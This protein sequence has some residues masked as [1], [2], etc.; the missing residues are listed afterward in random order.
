MT[1]VRTK[2]ATT[3]V[4]AGAA[5]LF[6]SLG[7]APARPTSTL[8]ESVSA[9]SARAGW[10]PD[11]L[12]GKSGKLWMRLLT[13][14]RSDG[15]G[16]LR[17]L[18]GDSVADRPGVYTT[19]DSGTGRPFTFVTLVPFASKRKGTIGSYRLGAWPAEKRGKRSDA[20]ANPDGFIEVT[21]DN[22]ETRVSEHFRLRD[23]LTRDQ[24]SVWPK[25]LLLSEALLD[26]LELVIEALNRRGVR[27][28]RLLVL[29]GFRTPSY[30]A[31]GVGSG[32]R[33]PD[34]RHQFG[35][36]AD[37]IVDSDGNGRMDDLNGDGRVNLL[38]ARFLARVVDE[39]ERTHTDLL[40][41]VG[42]YASSR[43]H[44]PFV[45]VDARG[46]RARWG[47]SG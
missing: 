6:A 46:I 39:I 11:T 32:G 3:I 33:A 1:R 26:K 10:H 40:G 19:T 23:F 30:N 13:A 2:T 43:V 20:Y 27:A 14:R 41:G 42:V 12:S 36:A 45:H 24:P 4:S 37:V 7:F 15:I 22:Q 16:V 47:L 9:E 21:P 17:R 29:S 8:R 34:S 28:E 18:F 38:D 31:L 25:Y 44:G 5:L 35:D